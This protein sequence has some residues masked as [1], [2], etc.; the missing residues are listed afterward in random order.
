[1]SNVHSNVSLRLL[2]MFSTGN[3][4]TYIS[5]TTWTRGFDFIQQ[6]SKLGNTW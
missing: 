2:E 5:M 4:G 6:Q 3:L 1:M